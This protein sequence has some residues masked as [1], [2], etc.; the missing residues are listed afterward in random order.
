MA[1]QQNERERERER[2]E[3][4]WKQLE[5][6]CAKFGWFSLM[7]GVRESEGNY[8]QNYGQK[9]MSAQTRNGE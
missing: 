4:N 3:N 5:I 1:T 6:Y 9:E 7:K 8:V 2:G